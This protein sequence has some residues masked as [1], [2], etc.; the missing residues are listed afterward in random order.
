MYVRSKLD[1]N[2]PKGIAVRNTDGDYHIFT[3]ATL[4]QVRKS[5]PGLQTFVWDTTSRTEDG[6]LVKPFWREI[7]DHV[8]DSRTGKDF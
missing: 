6:V 8:N 1:S 5:R 2:T 4:E 7:P 3:V